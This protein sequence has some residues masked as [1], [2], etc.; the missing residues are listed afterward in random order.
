MTR[1]IIHTEE[2]EIE[3][4]YMSDY[5]QRVL[6]DERIEKLFMV[7]QIVEIDGQ[8]VQENL[9]KVVWMLGNPHGKILTRDEMPLRL[10]DL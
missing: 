2:I 1:K 9:F 7:K 6:K 4:Q 5:F 10:K 3:K 8:E